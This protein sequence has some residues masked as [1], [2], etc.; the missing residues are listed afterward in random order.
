MDNPASFGIPVLELAPVDPETLTEPTPVSEDA[1]ALVIEAP[2]SIEDTPLDFNAVLT[3]AAEMVSRKAPCPN[4]G[5]IPT[6]YALY[7]LRA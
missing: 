1:P 2:P 3:Q 7:V 5:A 6:P 4:E